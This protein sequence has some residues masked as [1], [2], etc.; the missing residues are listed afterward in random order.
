M[1]SDRHGHL[2]SSRYRLAQQPNQATP[3]KAMR[4]L[5]LCPNFKCSNL[6]ENFTWF[7]LLETPIV[8]RK[9]LTT[10]SK[11]MQ[12]TKQSVGSP[13]DD[14]PAYA[15]RTDGSQFQRYKKTVTPNIRVS[16]KDMKVLYIV[17]SGHGDFVIQNPHCLLF[18][19]RTEQVRTDS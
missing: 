1:D 2:L 15:W 6:V 12:S 16:S 10:P 11:A 7:Q 14:R 5:F 19:H 17:N 9:P 13:V 8:V 4:L 18:R 3:K